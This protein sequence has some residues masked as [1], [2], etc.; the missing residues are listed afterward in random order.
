MASVPLTSCKFL[1]FSVHCSVFSRY[2]VN[3]IQNFSFS[4][5]LH[6]YTLDN[7]WKC[8]SLRLKDRILAKISENIIIEARSGCHLWM[9][10]CG[11]MSGYP[12]MKLSNIKLLG[13]GNI[14]QK[15]FR[16]HR[17]VCLM[18]YKDGDLSVDTRE[19][20]HICHNKRCVNVDHLGL[21][22][23]QT[24]RKD[25]L[26]GIWGSVLDTITTHRVVYPQGKRLC[27]PSTWSCRTIMEK[28]WWFQSF[29]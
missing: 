12:Q 4:G 13:G 18:V 9:K 1:V 23:A 19:A 2:S 7:Y 26:A 14:P 17:L 3:L 20:S 29:I 25:R 11:G 28:N 16:V 8:R 21:K 6:Y 10:S 22:A 5:L 24:M 15:V 27:L